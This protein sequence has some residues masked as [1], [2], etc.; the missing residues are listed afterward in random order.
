MTALLL[1]TM[2]AAALCALALV[3]LVSR[4]RGKRRLLDGMPGIAGGAPDGIG[5]SVLCSGL[6]DA[7][8][9][10]ELL[11][12]EYARYEVVVVLDALQHPQEFAELASRFRMIRVE[13]VPT[14]ELPVRGV[15]A[16][17]RSRRR[18]FRRLV[19]VDRAQD[20]PAGDFDA[21]M[22]VAAYDYLLPLR[23]EQRLLP[24]AVERLVTE[25]GERLP[26]ELGLVRSW[27]GVPAALYGREAVVA[28]GGF[29]ARPARRIARRKRR[30]LWEPLC[31]PALQPVRTPRA[32]RRLLALLLLLATAGSVAANRW[33]LA[34]ALL[35]GALVWA[36]AEYVRSLLCEMAGPRSAGL[37]AGLGRLRKFN[38]KNF[39]IS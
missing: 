14:R 6:K 12:V 3:V 9:I 33:P 8:R 19:L 24:G 25:A 16:L 39:T 5:I 10:E 23:A 2:A 7:A 20:A 30:I 22:S 28:A 34:A 38:V 27:L 35:T 32:V 11:S 26:G 13:Y 36:A 31:G 4:A 1:G 37:F 21:A 29:S 18:G 17:G 15:R